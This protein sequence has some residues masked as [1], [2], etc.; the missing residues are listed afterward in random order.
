M[1]ISPE[2]CWKL[3]QLCRRFR[4][5]V[6]GGRNAGKTTTFEKMT[7]S[8]EAAKPE[9]RDE[10]R[11]D[12]TPTEIQ[13][14]LTDNAMPFETPVSSSAHVTYRSDIPIV[15]C[16]YSVLFLLSNVREF[17]ARAIELKRIVVGDLVQI[18]TR[19]EGRLRLLMLV[20]VAR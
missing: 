3:R 17:Y 11:S 14:I 20:K 13:G 6:K 9:I 19:I 2:D 10:V 15:L 12:M 8:E 18:H 7:D 4:V 1:V 5:L 16:N